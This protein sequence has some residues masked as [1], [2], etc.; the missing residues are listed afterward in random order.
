M[1]YAIHLLLLG[2]LLVPA[3]A[4]E[5]ELV[6]WSSLGTYAGAAMMTA[7]AGRFFSRVPALRR[8]DALLLSYLTALA[9][10]LGAAAFGGEGLTLQSGLL[11]AFNAVVVALAAE[12]MS[13]RLRAG[14]T[15]STGD[16]GGAGDPAEPDDPDEGAPKGGA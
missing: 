8:L 4:A 5:G 2:L 7:V 6:T 16:T 3:A 14:D 13:S 10:L 1:K 9:L 12:G 15:G 11:C